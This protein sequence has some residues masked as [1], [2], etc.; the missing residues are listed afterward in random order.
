[1]TPGYTSL[2]RDDALFTFLQGNAVMICAGSWD[3]AVFKTNDLFPVGILPVLLPSPDDPVYGQFVLG[4]A[5][6]A[7][8][9]PEAA[10]GIVRTSKHPD[11]ALDFLRFLT[12]RDVA[13]RFSER[14]LRISSVAGVPPPS[15]APGLAPRLDGEVA[16]FMPDFNYFGGG[17]ANL[18]FQRN[19][20]LLMG[21]AGSVDAFARK[22]DADLPRALR[23][24]A[25]L[26]N[27]RLRRDIQ[28]L[29]ARLGILF[30]QP[31]AERRQSWTRVLGTLHAR[32]SDYLYYRPLGQTP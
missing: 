11:I 23:Q 19:L 8:G 14:S 29:D 16:G 4:L 30:T 18:V 24:D 26:Q 2:Q 7:S 9:S 17:N 25:G 28:T 22:L 5:S 12:S 1:M 32:Q 15:A 13:R 3:Y 10:L 20:Y 6:E 27:T 31:A 21:P